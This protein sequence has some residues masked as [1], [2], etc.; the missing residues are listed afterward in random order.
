MLLGVRVRVRSRRYRVT[1]L[2][3]L[4]IVGCCS[5][6]LVEELLLLLLLLVTIIIVVTADAPKLLSVAWL[7]S[8][9]PDSSIHGCCF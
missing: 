4:L 5:S 3:G 9:S 6:G 2:L 8:S 1:T 7:G